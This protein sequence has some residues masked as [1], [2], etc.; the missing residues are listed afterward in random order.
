MFV[1]PKILVYNRIPKCASSTIRAV[2][3]EVE[4][5][6]QNSVHFD[7]AKN[8]YFEDYDRDTDAK[9]RMHKMLEKKIKM[10]PKD[11]VLVI[12]GHWFQ[13]KIPKFDERRVEYM[14]MTRDCEDRAKSNLL[15]IL[16]TSSYALKAA[17][18][19]N[20]DAYLSDALN[21]TIVH[22]N[23]GDCLNSLA[24]LQNSKFWRHP[25]DGFM[26]KFFCGWKCVHENDEDL[27]T[28]AFNYMSDPLEFS[29]VGVLE[30]MTETLEMLECSYPTAFRGASERYAKNKTHKLP[31]LPANTTSAMSIF[32]DHTCRDIDAPL[33]EKTKKLFLRRYAEMKKDPSAC[34]R[35]RKESR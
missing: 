35:T 30:Y 3:N 20:T 10:T 17:K 2:L 27:A 33:Y 25:S 6:Y 34:C 18:A 15:F 8:Y 11:K 4:S 23:I 32:Q 19:N 29:A 22:G 14:Q 26:S 7:T 1:E 24:C 5:L 13:H 31:G 12:G 16:Q 9:K 28:G 21:T